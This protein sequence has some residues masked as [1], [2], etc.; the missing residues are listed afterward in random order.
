MLSSVRV[1]SGKY[2]GGNMII[3][4]DF[5]REKGINGTFLMSKAEG[6][7]QHFKRSPHI[8]LFPLAPNYYTL[9]CTFKTAVLLPVKRVLACLPRSN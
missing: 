6:V 8:V 9:G 2:T 7:F 3:K 5:S 4:W 1:S